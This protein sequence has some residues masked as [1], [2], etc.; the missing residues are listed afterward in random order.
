[1]NFEFESV[2]GLGGGMSLTTIPVAWMGSEWDWQLRTSLAE[3]T[4]RM[5]GCSLC[6][7]GCGPAARLEWEGCTREEVEHPSGTFP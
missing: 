2:H 1:M 4:D 5:A 7:R 3:G 6:Q